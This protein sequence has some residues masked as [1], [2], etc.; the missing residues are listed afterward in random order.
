VLGLKA[1]ATMP[2]RL[3]NT[4]FKLLHFGYHLFLQFKTEEKHGNSSVLTIRDV[5]DIFDQEKGKDNCLNGS[6]VHLYIYFHLKILCV[7]L[8]CL[9]VCLCT[10]YMYYLWRPED[11]LELVMVGICLDQRVALLGGVV[12]LE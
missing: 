1:L 9:H 12:L 8:I 11:P 7:W 2:T 4:I 3:V 6:V 10:T 5:G